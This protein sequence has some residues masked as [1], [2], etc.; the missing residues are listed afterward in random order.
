MAFRLKLV[1]DNTK[2]DFFRWQWLTF[3]LSAAAM[4]AF[5]ANSLL[6]R[7][8]LLQGHQQ[9]GEQHAADGHR[10][11]RVDVQHQAQRH[12]EQ[13]GVGQGV[14]EVGHAPPHHE[15]AERAGHQGQRQAGKQGVEEKVGHQ[16][17][18]SGP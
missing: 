18:Q 1:P 16:C 8:A 12:A 10:Q 14:A 2:I 6:C 11:R 4:L 9:H 17:L 5:A 3:G 7:L 13:G 15:G